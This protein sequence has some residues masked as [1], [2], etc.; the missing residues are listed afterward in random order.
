M[1]PE[2]ASHWRGRILMQI[3][4]E[5]TDKPQMKVKTHT[6]DV[7]QAAANYYQKKKYEIKASIAQGI[8]LPDKK[9]K[10]K[11][12]I[13]EFEFMSSSPSVNSKGF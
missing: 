8:C 10:V 5:Q 9:L 4:V 7:F 12:K 13:A 11:F 1:V 6:D 2:I 3:A